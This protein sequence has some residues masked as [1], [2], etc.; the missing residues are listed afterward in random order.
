MERAER[1]AETMR[2]TE[3]WADADPQPET[4]VAPSE[5]PPSALTVAVRPGSRLA[6]E[7]A[8][9]PAQAW[10][11]TLGSLVALPVAI[12]VLLALVVTWVPWAEPSLV[13]LSLGG[14]IALLAARAIGRAAPRALARAR[15]IPLPL[16]ALASSGLGACVGAA[17]GAS[18]V[19]F[20]PS[21]RHGAQWIAAG[22]S[23]GLAYAGLLFLPL[24]FT[25]LGRLSRPTLTALQVGA[26]IVADLY[27]GWNASFA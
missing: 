18:V 16:V 27:A 10:A 11:D 6:A 1:R 19:L 8:L 4:N 2:E 26:L 25:R 7:L 23:F 14:A 20:S 17:F 5:A 12:Y 24:L 22:A 9:G 3:A 21:L 15:R 13:G